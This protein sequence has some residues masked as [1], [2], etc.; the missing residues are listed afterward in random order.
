[1]KK[2]IAI[3]LAM[4]MI[5]ASIAL[6]SCEKKPVE[7]ATVEETTVEEV[8]TNDVTLDEDTVA[9][10]V[11]LEETVLEDVSEVAEPEATEAE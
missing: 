3:A 11:T 7:D 5:F 2:I 1:M 4:L 6:I 8:P 9:E 10:D